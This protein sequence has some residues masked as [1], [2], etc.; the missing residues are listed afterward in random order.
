LIRLKPDCGS[1]VERS[2][3]FTSNPYQITGITDT[4]SAG[5]PLS[6]QTK[7]FTYDKSDRLLTSKATATGNGNVGLSVSP[8]RLYDA[9]VGR[10]MSRDPIREAGGINLYGYVGGSPVSRI[11][12]SGLDYGDEIS[13]PNPWPLIQDGLGALGEAIKGALRNPFPRNIPIAP[14]FLPSTS[15]PSPSP[16]AR[17]TTSPKTKPTQEP[18]N[19]KD[20]NR[21][22]GN[23]F[24]D[25]ND[26]LDQYLDIDKAQQSVRKGI[27]KRVIDSTNKSKQR[28]DNGNRNLKNLKD[29]EEFYG[30]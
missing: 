5:H 4:A 23:R 2:Y 16:T 21:G 11:D 17:P 1:G 12:P 14:P 22:K 27:L 6:S 3:S 29:I 26:N 7:T 20:P 25:G 28:L 10:W 13:W 18:C 19:N 30:D 15:S 9:A 8:T 24:K